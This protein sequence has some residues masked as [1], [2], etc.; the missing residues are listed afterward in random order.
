MVRPKDLNPYLSPRAFYGAELRRLREEAELSQ[1]ALGERAFCSGTYIG[2]FETAERRPQMDMSKLFD[3][4]FGTGE[5]LQRLCRL[6]HEA[7]KHPDYYATV[8]ELEKH[9]E[10][11]SIFTQLHL[12]GLVQTEEYI[13]ALTRSAHP[14]ATAEEIEKRVSGRV[15]QQKMILSDATAPELWF[16]VHEAALRL[17][18]GGPELMRRQLDRIVALGRDHHRVLLQVMPFSAGPNPLIH[19]TV[20][21]LTFPD[22]PPVAYTEGSFSG[23]LI[24]EPTLV[25]QYFRAYDHLR[26]IALPPGP[27]LKLI[28]S[29]AK[30]LWTP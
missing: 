6:A 20:V 25:A 2:Q 4:I 26:A 8:A 3:E 24:E 27:S 29:V 23:Q 18:M 11:Y 28:E 21:L 5:H 1:D 9:A 13:R 17:P 10:T 7:E 22:A 19:G 30:D 15:D 16:T 14:F 12:P